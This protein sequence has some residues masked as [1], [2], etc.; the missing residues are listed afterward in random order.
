MEN[1]KDAGRKLQHA[2]ETYPKTSPNLP[3]T[4]WNELQNRH[5]MEPYISLIPKFNEQFLRWFA[6]FLCFFGVVG[7]I[8][9]M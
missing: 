6:L 1:K 9:P 5:S 3:K 2:P 4:T 8:Q 7:G